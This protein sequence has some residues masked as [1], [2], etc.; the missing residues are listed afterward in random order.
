MGATL[1]RLSL[2]IFCLSLWAADVCGAEP[3]TVAQ[4]RQIID[5]IGTDPLSGI[6]RMGPD[7]ATVAILPV[8]ASQGRFNIYLLD[9]P[10]MS[11]IPG[12]LIGSAASTGAN[13]TYDAEFAGTGKFV[14]KRQ[15]FIMT[16]S[17]DGTL[18]FKSYK[19]GKKISLWR[20]L[21]YLFR[22][23]VSDYNT[24]PSAVD[25]AVRLYPSNGPTG[26]ILL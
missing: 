12:G 26:P 23:S 10:D 11:V 14:S 7:G 8:T 19:K 16:L 21:P 5:S 15:R 9:S 6:W 20:W 2:L 4:A 24:R 22:F 13:G 18:G 17:P 25:G 3:M 1:S